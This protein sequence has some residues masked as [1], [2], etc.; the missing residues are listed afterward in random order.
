[1]ITKGILISNKIKNK[2]FQLS[3]ERK[4][5]NIKRYKIYRNKLSHVK[6][7]PKKIFFKISINSKHNLKLLWKTINDITKFKNKQRE[8]I[9]KTV[10]D[11]DKII[12]NSA[13]TANTCNTYFLNI[14]SKLASK[15]DKPSNSRNCSCNSFIL[16]KIT[17]FF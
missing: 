2:L 11:E 7:Q 13:N 5:E 14:G 8:S 17:S 12:T 15:I 9:K 6:K 10:D 4:P 16:N 3:L 1:M